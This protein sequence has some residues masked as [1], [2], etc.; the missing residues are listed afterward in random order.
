MNHYQSDINGFLFGT[1]MEILIDVDV[2]YAD[3]EIRKIDV[4]RRKCLFEDERPLRFFK[5]YTY[6]N[7]ELECWFNISYEENRCVP[8]YL[9]RDAT[10]NMCE[11]ED[12]TLVW[13][14]EEKI[15]LN[16]NNEAEKICNC[17]PDCNQI[18]YKVEVLSEMFVDRE[19]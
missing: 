11:I 17:Y 9:V 5:K 6:R 8:Y 14:N 4:N 16:P 19:M 1:F 10:T 2:I 15:R 7:C 13:R 3:D 12:F 18:E